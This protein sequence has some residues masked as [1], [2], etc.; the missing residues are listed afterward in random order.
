MVRN[1]RHM[2]NDLKEKV[3]PVIRQYHDVFAWGPEDMPGLDTKMAKHCLNV[4]PEVEPVKHKK[5]TFA[6]KRQKVI[7]AEVEKLLEAK[8]IEEIEYFDW[9][10]NEVVIK[11]SNGKWKICVDYTDLNKA[12]PKDNYL[13]PSID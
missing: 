9:L 8:F 12:C 5:R 13:L 2:E 1:G 3:I 4:Q 11:K 6:A 10:A 7:E